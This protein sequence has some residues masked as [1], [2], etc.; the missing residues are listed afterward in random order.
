MDVLQW[1]SIRVSDFPINSTQSTI[2][3]NLMQIYYM[4]NT[5]CYFD[6]ASDQAPHFK[7][8]KNVD[9]ID[10]GHRKSRFT[11]TLCCCA[12]GRMVDSDCNQR[13]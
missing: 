2:A 13:T 11:V 8:D 7:G 4:D 3:Y 12:G 1:K 6:M 5:Q 10:T 9:G